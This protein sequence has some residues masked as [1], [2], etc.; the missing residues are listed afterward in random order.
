MIH[1]E[2]FPRLALKG[3]KVFQM[4][5]HKNDIHKPATE[6]TKVKI[7]SKRQLHHT[8]VFIPNQN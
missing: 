7:I 5:A 6:Y 3:F 8:V 4:T 2:G 1:P